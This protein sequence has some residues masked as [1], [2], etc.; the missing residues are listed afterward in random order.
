MNALMRLEVFI[1]N[2]IN[3]LSNYARQPNAKDSVIEIRN[4]EI[5]ELIEIFNCLKRC[6]YYEDW[7][8][9]EEKMAIDR[10]KDPSL[11][12][13]HIIIYYCQNSSRLSF[14]EHDISNND[15]EF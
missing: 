15:D 5:K 12:G 3:S 6:K 4:K 10:V 1:K 8:Q 14:I 11:T 2:L 9:I 7:K 13:H